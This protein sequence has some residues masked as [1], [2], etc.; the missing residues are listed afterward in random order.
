MPFRFLAGVHGKLSGVINVGVP[1]F[2]GIV[3]ASYSER[4][5]LENV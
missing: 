4:F 3:S 5:S 1:L 2:P